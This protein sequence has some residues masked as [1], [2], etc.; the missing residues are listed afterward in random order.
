M[1]KVLLELQVKYRVTTFQHRNKKL[2]GKYKGKDKI[3]RLVKLSFNGVIWDHHGD[4]IC[5][6]ILASWLGLG[7]HWTLNLHGNLGHISIETSPFLISKSSSNLFKYWVDVSL[8][9]I[10]P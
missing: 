9:K 3:L 7:L 4:G 10:L 6:L 1:N 2:R 8:P 5:I